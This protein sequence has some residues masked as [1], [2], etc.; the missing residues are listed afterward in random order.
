MTKAYFTIEVELP[1]GVTHEDFRFWAEHELRCAVGGTAPDDPLRKLKR[2]KISVRSVANPSIGSFYRPEN[3]VKASDGYAVA[4][5][6]NARRDPAIQE[7]PGTPER[8]LSHAG[9]RVFNF[10]FSKIEERLGFKK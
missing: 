8:H 2:D 9:F 10:D 5:N 1:D 6:R 7:L 4:K 3:Y